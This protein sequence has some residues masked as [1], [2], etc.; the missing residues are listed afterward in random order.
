MIM[1]APKAPRGYHQPSLW[2]RSRGGDSCSRDAR[3]TSPWT[4]A[5]PAPA[6]PRAMSWTVPAAVVTV[7]TSLACDTGT[8]GRHSLRRRIG[9]ECRHNREDS[10]PIFFISTPICSNRFRA[11]AAGQCEHAVNARFMIFLR[12]IEGRCT[13]YSRSFGPADK[14]AFRRAAQAARSANARFGCAIVQRRFWTYRTSWQGEPRRVDMRIVAPIGEQESDG[15]PH[16]RLL[17]RYPRASHH[18]AG[19]KTGQT[20]ALLRFTRGDRHVRHAHRS[21]ETDDYLAEWRKPI[22]FGLRRPRGGSRQG[23]RGVGKRL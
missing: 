23:G 19:R 17:A 18:Q 2:R 9:G 7:C 12:T 11:F 22:P 10:I 14:A 16:Y 15:R 5:V 13:A 1:P 21:R 8:V 4:M 20:R 3:Y 6:V